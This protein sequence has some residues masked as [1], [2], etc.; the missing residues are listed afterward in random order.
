MLRKSLLWLSF[1]SLALIG[2]FSIGCGSSSKS[3]NT[4]CTGGPYNVVGDWQ[5]T[6]TASG[7]P[8]VT[9]YGA[10]DSAGQALFFDS[11]GDTLQMPALTGACSYTGSIIAYPEPNSGFST[12]T[13]SITGNVTSDSAITGTFSGTS[14]GTVSAATF[15]PLTGSATALSGPMIAEVEGGT[16]ILTVTM[17]PATGNNMTFTG[18][19]S[20]GCTV[21]GTFTQVATS[22]VFDVSY[23]YS[24]GETCAASTSTG[25]GF[26]SNT[27]YFGFD[28]DAATTY[29]YADILAT[30]GP[31]VLEF[32]PECADCDSAHA[33]RN[34]KGH[35]QTP[36]KT[37]SFFHAM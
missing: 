3:T 25:I 21:S 33:S 4:A 20:F 7:T 31:F 9:G 27:D 15:A 6:V 22:N 26:E 16:D 28:G 34:S 1:V 29:F 17:T 5:I 8:A 19:D 13:D 11:S 10:I 35:T 37:S 24:G 23:T 32:F 12:V 14:S 18:S 36:D 2:A 30:S